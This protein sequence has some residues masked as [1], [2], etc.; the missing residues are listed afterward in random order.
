M[1]RD[2]ARNENV[3][4]RKIKAKGDL[5]PPSVAYGTSALLALLQHLT[6][7][8]ALHT[9][10]ERNI[11]TGVARTGIDS[12]NLASCTTFLCPMSMPTYP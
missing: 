3:R 10:Y 7:D 1:K 9:R 4:R 8:H 6:L 2:H 11:I 5:H 12:S